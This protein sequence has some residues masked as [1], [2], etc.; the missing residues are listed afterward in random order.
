MEFALKISEIDL[1][2]L[3]DVNMILDYENSIRRGITKA[4]FHYA[5]VNN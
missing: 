1:K 4:V 3:T 5:E 2:L